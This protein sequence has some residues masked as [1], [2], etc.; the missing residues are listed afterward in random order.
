[1]K[2]LWILI[3]IIYFPVFGYSQINFLDHNKAV[4][5]FEQAKLLMD[6]ENYED[7]IPYLRSSIQFD[8][9]LRASYMLIYEA[10]Y[11]SGN[12]QVARDYLEKAKTIFL[13]DDEVIYYL[14]KVY[15]K[16]KNYLAA[17]GEFTLAIKYAKVN[18]EDLPIIYDYY[19]SRG[20]CYLK[21]K[22]YQKALDD[23]DDALRFNEVEGSIYVNRGY[24]LYKLEQKDTAC[25]SWETALELGHTYVQTYLDKFCK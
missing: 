1:M 17:L 5:E 19:A 13:E 23:F 6:K 24:A 11:V 8:S 14:A 20:V 2:K 12:T 22:K 3:T 9:T 4:L 18:G 21:Q 16:E 10:G 25:K 7:A 15:Q